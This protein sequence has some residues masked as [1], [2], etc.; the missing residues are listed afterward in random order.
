MEI[1]KAP[2]KLARM[3]MVIFHRKSLVSNWK[4]GQKTTGRIPGGNVSRFCLFLA[5]SLPL[6]NQKRDNKEDWVRFKIP[7]SGFYTLT[8]VLDTNMKSS[9][10]DSVPCFPSFS[11]IYF[12]VLFSCVYARQTLVERGRP[13]RGISTLPFILFFFFHLPSKSSPDSSFF[14]SPHLSLSIY[15]ILLSFFS[16]FFNSHLVRSFVIGSSAK[17]NG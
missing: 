13:N 16:T 8:R 3:Y 6:I 17:Q 10:L 14:V 7:I 9:G 15:T 12:L 11:L 1:A 5:F 2:H 4:A